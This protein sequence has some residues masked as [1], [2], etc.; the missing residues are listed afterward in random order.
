MGIIVQKFGGT[1][2][3]SIERIRSA[4]QRVIKETEQGNQVVVVVSAM[5]K[6]TDALVSLAAQLSDN[7]SKREMD[8]LLSTGEQVTIALL[9]M[10]LQAE[11]KQAVSLTGWQAGIETEEFPSNARIVNIKTERI[12]GLLDKGNIVIVAGFQGMV[13]ESGE[14]T[15][16]GRGGS[17]TTAVA[18]AA[19]LGAARCDIYTDV[20]GVFTTDP[21]V[22]SSARKIP[23][24][25]YDEMLEMAN[26]GAGVLHPRAV[27]F[28]KNY[29]VKLEV[30]SSQEEERGTLV[31]EEATMEQNLMVRGLAF[32]G[33]IT[34]ITVS[35]LPNGIE[36][37]SSLFST[38]ADNG[39]NV[40][41][42]IQNVVNESTT[43][44][45]F[46]ID[47]S[48]LAETQEVL[49]ACQEELGFES[50]ITEG[51]LAKVSIVGSGMIS[52]PGV[53]AKMFKG[54]S[55][56]GIMI[57]MVSTSEIKVSTVVSQADM[58]NAVETLHDVFELDVRQPAH[59]L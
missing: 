28:A 24:I 11:G 36:T 56:K 53:A 1:S 41:I 54:L 25:S 37:L 15:T 39:I 20:T 58:V 59:Q 6:T 57:K 3:G 19:A 8:M 33:N 12:I 44:I 42:I 26:L 23:S 2:V 50:I 29:Q 9:S 10:A 49:A 32:E 52:N 55:Q 48:V 34:K 47:S 16:L 30:R 45:S 7:P 35:N 46:S 4:A 5:G 22:V 31:E 17:D 40:D 38:L 13:K 51:G 14:I 21:R 18:L 43:N 27:E